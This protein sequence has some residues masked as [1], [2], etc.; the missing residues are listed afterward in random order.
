MNLLQITWN[1]DPEIFKVGGFSLRYYSLLFAVAFFLG[2]VLLKNI[3]RKEGW[4]EPL[5][6]PLVIYIIAGTVIGARLGQVLFYEFGYYKDHFLE[7]LFPFRIS[8]G[9]FEWTG[10]QGLASHGGAV[11]ILL[12]V[13]LYARKYKFSVLWVLDRLVIVVALGGF[14]IRLGNFFNS[15]I[16]GLP[17]TLPWAVVFAKVDLVPR[18]PAQLYEALA[19]LFIFIGLWFLYKRGGHQ[20][21]GV[22]FGWFLVLVFSARFLIEFVKTDQKEFERSLVLNM[23]QLLSIPFVLAGLY[24]LLRDNKN[25][26]NGLLITNRRVE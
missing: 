24:F 13:W 19:Y 26:E 2:Y 17:S 25:K 6:S 23:G 21:N 18:H 10:Y 5:L 11:G 8:N 15:E 20:Q 14:F 1:T 9:Q 3:Y 22:L 7:M 16:L 4:D 12:A